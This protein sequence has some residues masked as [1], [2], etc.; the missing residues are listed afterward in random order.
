MANFSAIKASRWRI[1]CLFCTVLL[2]L[3]TV[4]AAEPLIKLARERQLAYR[5]DEQGNRVP[6]FSHCGYQLASRD[7]PDVPVKVF[8]NPGED[9]QAALNYV[10]TL[11]L[12]ANGF[13]GAVRLAPGEFEIYT[14]I[15]FK[16]SG[17]VLQGSGADVTKLL[18]SGQ[19]RD[20]AI[21]I[22]GAGR[23]QLVAES[24]AAIVDDYVPVG[25]SQFA[26]DDASQLQVGDTVVVTRPATPDWI[27]LV[28]G[29][30]VGPSWKP[31][32]F[33]LV[34]DRTLTAIEGRQITVDA[35]IT[36]ALES[37]F[38]GGTIQKYDWPKRLENVG[39]EDLT[40]VS[41]CNLGNPMNEDHSWYGVYLD[42]V[43]NAWVRRVAMHQFAGG[44]VHLGRDTKAITVEDC[45]SYEPVSEIGGYR[46]H[47]YF[48]LGQL[49]LFNR[50]WSEH[51]RHD[52]SVGYASA[53]P[54]AFVQCRAV[55]ALGDSGPIE[56]W[57]TGVLY[58]N[59]RISGA[60]LRLDNL[61]N[62]PP[63]TGWAAANC[64]L[65]N[66]RAADVRCFAP[67]GATN[68]CVGAWATPA[69][70]G[71]FESLSDTVRPL[72][73][74]Q[75]QLAA[76]VDRQAAQRIEPLLGDPIASTSPSYEEAAGFVSQSNEPARTLRDVVEENMAA[77]A[78]QRK[79][80][81]DGFST[82][83]FAKVV[84]ETRRDAT[85][86]QP[87]SLNIASGWLTVDGQVKTGRRLRPSWWRG[88]MHTEVA[89][90]F[91]FNATRFVPG[92]FG[93]G[94]T[95]DLERMANFFA[96]QGFAC[97]EHH[98]GLWYERRRD[99]HLMV[100]RADGDVAPPFYEQP[101][102]RSGQG[103]AWD[104][105]SKYD[106]TELNP[107]YWD[108]LTSLAALGLQQG[109]V[110]ANQHYFQHNIIEA[111]AHWVDC[112]WRPANNINDVEISEPPPFIGDKRIFLA[113][114]FYDLSKPKLREL[115]RNYI[116][117]NL[118]EFKYLPS[119]VHLL[120]AEYTGPLEFTQFWLDTIAE[121][122]DET[123]I[124]VLVALSCTK[125]V[126]DAI[127]ADPGRAARVELID[128]RYWTYDR[129]GKLYAPAG[130]LSMAPR[131]HMRQL[132]PEAS[133]FASI[134]QAVREYRTKFPD[135]AVLYNGDAACR[136]GNDGWAV[137]IGGG[138]LADVQLP[139]ELS[140]ALVAMK[141]TDGIVTGKDQWALASG[142]GGLLIYTAD[143]SGTLNLQLSSAASSYQAR[144]L[145]PETGAIVALENLTA[146]QA[147]SPTVH[148]KVLWL[149][150]A[151]Q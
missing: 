145:K 50:C 48:T 121:W 106:L 65:W 24:K 139:A 72:S 69:G 55:R 34:W 127:L 119:V 118:S 40:L 20:P 43:Q 150:P 105:L 128:I 17:V 39:I 57:A 109:F 56:S 136:S 53:G 6:D 143:E 129:N 60:G 89:A 45:A 147:A 126:Q 8:L 79:E 3:Q 58:D 135:K 98:Y 113:H 25:A 123:G 112:P 36:T 37:K 31:E 103:T 93:L 137:L 52:F 92:R 66:C 9:I 149:V 120:S 96:A 42:R 44:A 102:A 29:R 18:T 138:S 78:K 30:K 86:P 19:K 54:N 5:Q 142:E 134:V 85:V 49:A 133:S 87:K 122:E 94:L 104:G 59:V 100:R 7:I 70:D 107:W 13:R 22:V 4:S 38:G 10:A 88:S 90:G 95:N 46:R 146:A 141:P 32:S 91:G 14:K 64:L 125:D 2:T 111:G 130:G 117:A 151:K 116:R 12:D 148:S 28:G 23:R 15:E 1:A 76:R 115:H 114:Q 35:P 11:P 97:Y 71:V 73:L 132:R 108:R 84:S 140:T 77:M 61:W 63:G 99:D 21:W 51:G 41:R 124:D 81:L 101:F 144:W 80:E 110:L 67:P 62:S 83:E 131:Q 33:N 82:V 16:A 47:T 27:E 75:A 26:V 68:W 74:Y